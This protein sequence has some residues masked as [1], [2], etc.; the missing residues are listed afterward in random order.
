MIIINIVSIIAHPLVD[1]FIIIIIKWIPAYL[2]QANRF[3][4][5]EFQLH[6]LSNE[7]LQF[8]STILFIFVVVVVVRSFRY[9]LIARHM[10][11]KIGAFIYFRSI[12]SSDYYLLLNPIWHTLDLHIAYV[13]REISSSS[14][15]SS[16]VVIS[17][18]TE[19]R[20]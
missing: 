6:N 5:D 4:N 11:L 2:G 19:F 15:R 1:R 17:D 12:D 7:G 16:S 20:S 3:L 10:P 18:Y 9:Q 8:T 14:S 13:A